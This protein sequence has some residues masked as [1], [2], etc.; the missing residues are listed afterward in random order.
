[1]A[2]RTR[3][4]RQ[5]GRPVSQRVVVVHTTGFGLPFGFLRPH[6]LRLATDRWPGEAPGVTGIDNSAEQLR[7]AAR[8]ADQ[9]GVE[10]E[11]IHGNAETVP[12]PDSS[13]D[14]AIS[15]YGAAIWVRS[16]FK[17]PNHRSERSVHRKANRR[18]TLQ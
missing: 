6:P 3:L 1:M 14:L 2:R 13:F 11:L 18:T 4:L 12:M 17:T 5:G 15:E 10:L 9:H 8:L 16:W 7:T